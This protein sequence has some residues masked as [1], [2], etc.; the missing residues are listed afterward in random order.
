MLQNHLILIQLFADIIIGEKFMNIKL[1]RTLIVVFIII[2][3]V[4]IWT[5]RFQLLYHYYLWRLNHH[6]ASAEIIDIIEKIESISPHIIYSLERT[7]VD[8]NASYWSRHA[9]ALSLAKT[10]QAKAETLFLKVLQN[11]ADKKFISKAIVD[12]G[13]VR[14]VK[15][16]KKII[17]FKNS[18]DEEIRTA[19]IYYLGSIG[20]KKSIL[21][22]KDIMKNDPNEKIRKDAAYRL[23]L[24]G[25][26]PSEDCK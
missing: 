1:R 25:I 10:D 5:K 22:L 19:L 18:N 12:L 21:L 6:S 3:S 13:N 15:A 7:Y 9:A 2:L 26:I 14:S 17:Q 11:K 23:Q 4:S 24:I 8:E 20:D 16:Y